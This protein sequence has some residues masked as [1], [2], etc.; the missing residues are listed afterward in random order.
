[1]DEIIT[2]Y[3][4]GEASD[5]EKKQLLDWLRQSDEN[6]K[7]FSEMRDVWLASGAA[8]VLGK[9]FTEKGFIRFSREVNN[10]E[11]HHSRRYHLFLR[12]A[13]AIALL[14]ICSAGGYWVGRQAPSGNEYAAVMNRVIMGKESKG[15]VTL[16]DGTVAWL[17]AGSKLIYP[18]AFAD[19]C[20]RVKLEG[21]GYFE[22]VRNEKSPFYVETE[23]MTV[24]V[25]GTC[26]DVKNYTNRAT[27]E[28]TLLSGKVE[29]YFPTT[30]KRIML[31]PNQKVSCDKQTG[32][33]QLSEVKAADYVV[34]IQD[35]LVF[36]NEKLSIILP[37]MEKWYNVD[38]VCDANVPMEQ[39]L[40][41]TIRRE[42]KEEI[43][44][45]LG[46]ISP[47]SCRVTADKV[48]IQPK[49]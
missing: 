5:E 22:V 17:N 48:Y 37:Q 40:S 46:L 21:E 8:P 29:V 24:N 44:K 1:M 39:R 28:T 43:F 18:E 16:P 6:K 7:T 32:A 38:I 20:R 33:W 41:L 15:A 26:F 10:Y 4:Q 3:L 14:L 2:R 19:D 25:L 35:K 12:I 27:T 11:K 34:W 47:I 31:K 42:N 9:S 36:T 49:K 13:A 23:Q 30:N 45:L